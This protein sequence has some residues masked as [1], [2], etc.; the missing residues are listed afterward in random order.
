MRVALAASGLVV[1]AVLSI[2][3]GSDRGT[4]GVEGSTPRDAP[5]LDGGTAFDG[6]A[7]V[8][9]LGESVGALGAG[10]ARITRL[11]WTEG[12][13]R[14]EQIEPADA[15]V[16]HAIVCDPTDPHA[17]FAATG[18]EARLDRWTS[19]L[20]G[21]WSSASLFSARYG[22]S[23]RVRDVALGSIL[24]PAPPNDRTGGPI[25]ALVIGTHDEGLLAVLPLGGDPRGR[26]PIEIDRAPR[27]L[28]HEVELGDLDGD[29]VREIYATRSPPNTLVPG[30]EQPGSVARYDLP[31]GTRETVIELAPRH[32]KEI[33]VADVDADG[34][35]ELY[36]VVEAR[37]VTEAGATRV[38]EPVEVRR[39]TS[40]RPA[41]GEPI[42][43]FDD[44]S[45]RF[46]AMGELDGDA[47]R[48][49]V[50]STFSA[51]L[52]VLRPPEARDGAAV[53]ADDLRG[54]VWSRELVDASSGGFEHALTLA[55]LDRDGRDE[56]YA[57]DDPTG[58]LRR[59]E[60]GADGWSHD[61]LWAREAG[62]A[63][64]TWSVAVCEGA[65]LP[66]VL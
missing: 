39:I 55:D 57:M 47:G 21:A 36:V 25:D 41:P 64:I 38:V 62:L 19:D 43:R 44:R 24:R 48:E 12:A 5:P 18:G 32:A 58:E 46:L 61:I 40:E 20:S 60:R 42:A 59:H 10:R 35:D 15:D 31:S 65:N 54:A 9:L 7:A 2:V 11:S 45:A 56:I 8:L 34:R 29:G 33:L 14:V 66:R 1:A 6:G 53:T 23:S 13:L 30:I 22:P 51:G 52:W 27:T 50:I 49:L 17:F 16:V 26:D 63:G 4:S 28:I 3:V 37:L